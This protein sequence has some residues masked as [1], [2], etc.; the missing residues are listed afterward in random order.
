MIYITKFQGKSQSESVFSGINENLI[1]EK[2]FGEMGLFKGK[3][4]LVLKSNLNGG[5]GGTGINL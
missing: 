3:I 5:I 1:S 4:S 2:T